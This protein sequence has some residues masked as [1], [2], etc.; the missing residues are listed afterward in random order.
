MAK[1]IMLGGQVGKIHQK[2]SMPPENDGVCKNCPF[3]SSHVSRIVYHLEER[4]V[5]TTHRQLG[6]ALGIR[7]GRNGEYLRGWRIKV[8]PVAGTVRGHS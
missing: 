3:P 5:G 7:L 2:V 8:L 6:K 1:R 4:R